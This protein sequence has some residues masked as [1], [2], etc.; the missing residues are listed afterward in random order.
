MKLLR[1]WKSV[2]GGFGWV[3]FEPGTQ[4]QGLKL[5]VQGLRAVTQDGFSACLCVCVQFLLLGTVT[6][7]SHQTWTL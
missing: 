5:K 7:P 6:V 3:E 1:V 4:E 2:S